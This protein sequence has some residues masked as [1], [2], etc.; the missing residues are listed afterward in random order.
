MM[1]IQKIHDRVILFLTSLYKF[2]RFIYHYTKRC[3]KYGS[4]RYPYHESNEND[5][6][7][8]LAT[9][10]SLTKELE[11][12]REQ[13]VLYSDSLFVMNFFA[14]TDI[15]IQLKPTRYC[16]ADPGF[17]KDKIKVDRIM[18]LY[19]ALNS[20]V[21]W[22]MSL[23]VPNISEKVA[24][25]RV[26]NKNI[27]IIPIS[28]LHFEGFESH[29][30]FFY[31][32]GWA[33]PSFVNVLMMIEYVCLNEGFSKIYLYGADHTFLNGLV[34]GDDNILYV[35]DRH[36]YGTERVIADVHSDGTPWRISEFIY[37][38]Y[39]TFVEHDV[40]RKYADYLGAQIINCTQCSCIDSYIRISQLDHKL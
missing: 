40:M 38:K 39:L 30:N 25:S 12:L 11:Q 18:Q 20:V 7:R 13:G 27:K 4:C 1:I 10:P 36:F 35:E 16:L 21:D 26:T 32:K 6:I 29:R 34:V 14:L 3:I 24:Q 19:S 8:V 28:T 2:L 9:G 22:Q 23:Y 31:K 17:Y 15:F 5:S 33:T 37:D